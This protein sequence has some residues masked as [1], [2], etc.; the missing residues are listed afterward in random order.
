MRPAIGG[1]KAVLS[2]QSSIF[3][4]QSSFLRN[5][6]KQCFCSHKLDLR[7]FSCEC[8]ENLNIRILRIKFRNKSRFEESPPNL[9]QPDKSTFPTIGC[10]AP[11]LHLTTQSKASK[12][13]IINDS[14][15]QRSF[16]IC[17]L[18]I[19][20][21]RQKTALILI[22]ILFDSPDETPA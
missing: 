8:R 18:Q 2:P 1:E 19:Q 4:P 16:A 7:H 13:K 10:H 9:C 5:A 20:L 6:Q 12:T 3:N 11:V 14:N 22:F 17:S 21:R 15:Y